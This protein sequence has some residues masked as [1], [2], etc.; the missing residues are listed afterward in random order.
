MPQFNIKLDETTIQKIREISKSEGITQGEL[1]KRLIENYDKLRQDK[2][3]T[4]KRIITKYEGRCSKCGSKI[5]VGSM[6]F[7]SQGVLVCMDCYVLSFG[8][9]ALATRYLKM[10][11]LQLIIKE[12]R[13][14]ANELADMVNNYRYQ[15]E[16][17]N[18]FGKL[19]RLIKLNE[20]YYKT[21]KDEK[22]KELTEF[23]KKVA[24][25]FDDLRLI[26]ESKIFANIKKKKRIDVV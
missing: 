5:P 17:N 19:E 24:K 10:R 7:W 11:E 23:Y 3:I 20:D 18:L 26:I 25:D 4:L 6:A 8:D 16:L 1:I 22:I 2:E 15:S 14:E 12:L 13:K 21:F 9:K